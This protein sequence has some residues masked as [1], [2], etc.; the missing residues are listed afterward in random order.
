MKD[1][2]DVLIIGSGPAGCACAMALSGKGYNVGMVDKATFP[3]DK[4]CG[5]AIP[6]QT[7]TAIKAINSKWEEEL[8]EFTAQIPIT[9]SKVF[10][11]KASAI[12]YKWQSYACNSKRV[13]FDNR[14]ISIVKEQTTT[15]VLENE[16][17]INIQL[18]NNIVTTTLQNGQTITSA[19]VVGCDGAN[20]IVKRSLL[21]L[22]SKQSRTVTAIR[23]YYTGVEGVAPGQN[24]F[25]LGVGVDGYFWIFPLP[26]HSYNVG[27]GI[28]QHKRS[29]P[30]V[31]IRRKFDQIVGSGPLKERFAH[32]Q[33]VSKPHGARLSIWSGRQTISG[34]RFILAGDAASL[35]DPLQGHGI[36]KA[37]KSGFMAANQVSRCFIANN[38]T[39]DFMREYEKEIDD[40]IGK[41][42]KRSH[43]LMTLMIR[44]PFILTIVGLLKP[45]QK[46][47]DYFVKKINL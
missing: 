5:D 35:A 9:A 10:F 39:A 17:V 13:H 12:G 23:A 18:T 15:T 40:T 32:A 6:G 38:F 47:V 4:V 7:F 3:R 34:E 30:P 21:T 46:W 31:D 2:F 43:L 28:Y 11:S 1:T 44:F 29:T 14:L 33:L 42:L 22:R 16:E 37:I 41:E 20:S 8:R 36:D 45:P 27:L 24:E 26:D 19:M 25:H